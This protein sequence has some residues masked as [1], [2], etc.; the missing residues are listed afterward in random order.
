MK[1]LEIE[2]NS[3]KERIFPFKKC[4][5]K[6]SFHIN[7]TYFFQSFFINKRKLF[8]SGVFNILNG[9]YFCI[10]YSLFII[11]FSVVAFHDAWD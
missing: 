2:L 5:N 1:F 7:F 4:D 8:F 9:V 11:I 10:L 6:N 3:I